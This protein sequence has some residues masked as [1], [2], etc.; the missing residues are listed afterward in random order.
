MQIR[1]K[2]LSGER[3]LSNEEMILLIKDQLGEKSREE[4]VKMLSRGASLDDVIEHFLHHGKTKKEEETDLIETL[5][6]SVMNA[7]SEEEI[8]KLLEEKLS[9][10]DRNL[11]E[12]LMEEGK[13]MKE[14][15]EYFVKRNENQPT[16]SDLSERVK[17]AS[18]G[19]K[20]SN[21]EILELLK[22]NLG[23]SGKEQMESMVARGVP[24]EDVI[25]HFM[26]FGKTEEEEN[27]E[28]RDQLERNDLSKL[29]QAEKQDFLSK[30]LSHTN[31]KEME[32]VLKY[33]FSIDDVIEHF[34]VKSQGIEETE[35]VKTI[36]KLSRNKKLSTQDVVNLIKEQLSDD[37]KKK[38]AKMLKDGMSEKDVIDFFMKN[39][40]TCQEEQ[41][42]VGE[43]L[44][45]MS[46]N[47]GKCD[48]AQMENM[49]KNGCTVEEVF[50]MFMN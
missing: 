45:M 25:S 1:I 33:G 37:S 36:K 6:K 30:V 24:L 42:E 31:K 32:Q 7:S 3:K 18:G 23:N 22:D 41:R 4:S 2:K 20:L 9:E 12:T 19:R 43:N 39:G 34:Q 17:K 27:K 21:E 28:L 16:E 11:M 15:A 26:E 50:D 46:T 14:I 13:S 48:R 47:L 5:K 29:S 10:E 35:L 44:R 8:K 49:L 40:K 38:M